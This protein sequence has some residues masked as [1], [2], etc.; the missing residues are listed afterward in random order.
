MSFP[1]HLSKM[2]FLEIVF[3]LSFWS[4]AKTMADQTATGR[5]AIERYDPQFEDQAR[6]VACRA[7]FMDPGYSY[8]WNLS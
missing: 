5:G 3:S 2:N 8:V 1:F 4:E 7:F 6:G